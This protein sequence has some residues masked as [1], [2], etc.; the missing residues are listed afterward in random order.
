[1]LAL[2]SIVCRFPKPF[3]FFEILKLLICSI[4]NTLEEDRE[5]THVV[6]LEYFSDFV[7]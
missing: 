3:E 7:L 1:M 6:P 4:R 2:T 5:N